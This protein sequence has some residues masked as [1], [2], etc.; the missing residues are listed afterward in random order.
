MESLIDLMYYI[1][2]CYFMTAKLLNE[3]YNKQLTSNF[4]N[5]ILG[6][7]SYDVLHFIILIIF[8][9]LK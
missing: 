3:V 5:Q 7:S 1:M 9:T 6:L 8:L 2:N 4:L